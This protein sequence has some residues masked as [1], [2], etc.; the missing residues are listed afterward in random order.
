MRM[1][2]LTPIETPTPAPMATALESTVAAAEAETTCG[3]G[4]GCEVRS[5]DEAA[6]EITVGDGP[7]LQYPAFLILRKVFVGDGY[8]ATLFSFQV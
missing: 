1:S 5:V 3:G 2:K 6:V 8:I 4:E 7:L